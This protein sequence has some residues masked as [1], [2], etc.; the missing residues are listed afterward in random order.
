MILLP[1]VDIAAGTVARAQKPTSPETLARS[2]V[3]AGATHLHVV[4]LDAALRGEHANTTIIAELVRSIPAKIEISAGIRDLDTLH[5]YAAL[6]PW[7]LILASATIFDPGFAQASVRE[8]PPEQLT[9]ALDV[10]AGMA[11]ARGVTETSKLSAL[12]VA[13]EF[14]H[15]GIRR[16]IVTDISRDGTLVGLNTQ[17]VREI[18]TAVPG[19][20]VVASGGVRSL[21]D[22]IA[23]RDAGA[24]GVVLGRALLD[25]LISL[26]DALALPE[27]GS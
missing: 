23:A 25:G 7:Q 9:L 10:N 6:K 24:S 27:P 13:R 21:A 1:A 3:E 8:L 12:E 22:L 19:C 4:D 2:F 17:L 18:R 16:F 26:R 14:A 5:R 15:F 20:S 11:A